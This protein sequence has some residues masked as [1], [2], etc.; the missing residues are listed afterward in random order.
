MHGRELPGV[1]VMCA[2]AL[3]L[4]GAGCGAPRSTSEP[5]AEEGYPDWVRLVP[6]ATDD[7][8]YY[9]GSVSLARD[10]ESAFE[11]A[12][13]EALAQ[14]A[15]AGRR[16]FIR[17]FDR[18]AAEAGVETTSQER[19]E[20]RTGIADEVAG[21]LEPAAHREDVFYRLCEGGEERGTVCQ[22]FVLLRIDHAERDRI[23]NDSLAALGQRKQREGETHLALLI[24]WMLRNQ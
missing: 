4:L 12:E 1:L 15:E 8:S 21:H 22:A 2:I 24:E 16:R 23:F 13:S 3:S 11:A 20:F 7:A 19:L 17:L 5:A 18:A 14:A 6:E 10:P 9:V